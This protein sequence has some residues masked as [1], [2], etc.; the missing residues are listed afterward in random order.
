MSDDLEVFLTTL[1]ITDQEGKTVVNREKYRG[2]DGLAMTEVATG[3]VYGRVL[4]TGTDLVTFEADSMAGADRA[5]RDSV[6]HYLE[7]LEDCAELGLE[8]TGPCPAPSAD[9][10]K[11]E[12]GSPPGPPAYPGGIS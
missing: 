3:R 9:L 1:G 7:F 6:D 5:F 11:P 10:K 4:D 12:R 2:Y 8:P